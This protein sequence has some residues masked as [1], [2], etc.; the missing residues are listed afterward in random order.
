MDLDKQ[1]HRA[2][3]KDSRKIVNLSKKLSPDFDDLLIHKMRTTVKKLRALLRLQGS[4][5]KAFP[6]SFKKMYRAAGSIRDSQVL[7]ADLT[8][9]KK[10]LPR[11]A[12]WLATH[13]A[14][15]EKKWNKVYDH[16][17]LKKWEK[18]L[19]KKIKKNNGSGKDSFLQNKLEKLKHL[20][21]NDVVTDDT[22]HRGRKLVKD[23]QYV[24]EW[25]Q[26]IH[27]GN[28]N[29]LPLKKMKEISDMAGG[30]MDKSK[31]MELLDEYRNEEKD[32]Q[33]LN[34]ALLLAHE[35]ESE[36]NDEKRKLMDAFRRL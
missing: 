28:N 1:V 4:Y 35:W 32:E 29:D 23:M 9:N 16:R 21:N 14:K 17:K 33:A 22:I 36:K 13:I 20:G 7:L 19:Q 12:V 15:M 2:I 8:E 18:V 25:E 27:A 24:S 30:F 6:P 10:S 5:S 11:F 3:I 34:S 26:H 31:G